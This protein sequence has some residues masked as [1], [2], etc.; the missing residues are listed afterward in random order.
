MVPLYLY[1]V[2]SLVRWKQL[3]SL[4]ICRLTLQH[5]KQCWVVSFI[6]FVCVVTFTWWL[7]CYSYHNKNTGIPDIIMS[8]RSLVI[9]LMKC[10]SL[11]EQV[12]KLFYSCGM[13][14]LS[15]TWLLFLIKGG[16]EFWLLKCANNIA[17]FYRHPSQSQQLCCFFFSPLK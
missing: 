7:R 9:R 8:T 17:F 15:Q 2:V 4:K 11:T 6:Y 13:T 10:I 14:L 3:V 5:M 16:S 1:P 12:W